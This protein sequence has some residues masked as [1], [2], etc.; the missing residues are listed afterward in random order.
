[1]DTAQNLYAILGLSPDTQPDEIRD[2]YRVLARRF[3]PDV[4]PN[5]GAGIQ[6]RDIA[7]AYETLSNPA[8]RMHYDAV[9][10]R[11]ADEPNYYSLRV[12]SSKRV[13]AA[14]AEPQV[15][16]LLAEIIPL[17]QSPQERQRN[18]PLNIALVL[19]RS[20]S[21]H[22][23]R[24]EKVKY[25]AHQ[26]IDELTSND[27][28]SVVSF[29]DQADVLIEA[30]HVTNPTAMQSMISIMRADG[31]TEIY[32][33]LAA[34]LAQCR[35]YRGSRMVNH[36]ILLTDG[37]T[38]GDEEPALE[39]AAEAAEEGI[40]IS[41]MGIGDEWNDVFLDSLA[42]RTG[43]TSAYINSPAA[44]LR[45][46]NDRIRSLGR[47]YVERLSISVAPDADIEFESAFKLLPNPQ[48]LSGSPQPI[49]LGNLEYNRNSTVL[50]QLQ[51]PPSTKEGFRTVARLDVTGDVLSANRLGYKIIS[52]ISVEISR[53]PQTEEPPSAV[54]DALGKLSLYRMQ[55][56]AEQ[57][58]K[59]GRVDEATRRL[60][61]LATR[62]LAAGQDDLAQMA[63]SE[64]QRVSKTNMLSEQGRKTL[65]FGTR[66]LLALP[67]PGQ[68]KGSTTQ[69]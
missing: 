46:L 1:M 50:I 67:Q 39:L 63:M 5:E 27:I 59:E 52:D 41:A 19:D 17:R 25:A 47:S 29:S 12:T 45:F 30:E 49:L 31:G 8:Q 58:L 65:K 7:S 53:T 13:L 9:R 23:V 16:Y 68:D 37:R 14:L 24:L 40:G 11:Y 54:I 38:F 2:A 64:A 32:Q 22:G 43:G 66:R 4:N 35:K 21:M 55:Q 3:H 57:S 62:L 34:G 15:F 42:S 20:T 69:A 26:I 33:G 51:M 60:E 56:K 36:V 44:V 18:V 6:F 10:H 61:N 48:P 28:L